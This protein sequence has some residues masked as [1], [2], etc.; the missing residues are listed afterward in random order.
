MRKL[1]S[2]LGLINFV[3]VLEQWTPGCMYNLVEYADV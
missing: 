1:L 2:I 3:T